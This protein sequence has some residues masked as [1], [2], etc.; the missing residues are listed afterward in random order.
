MCHVT[1]GT[2]TKRRP[3]ASNPQPRPIRLWHAHAAFKRNPGTGSGSR[4]RPAD[5]PWKQG[6][7]E[8]VGSV[9]RRFF[10]PVT[11][12]LAQHVLTRHGRREERVRQVTSIGVQT[13]SPSV[14]RKRFLTLIRCADE[15]AAG[16]RLGGAGASPQA[17]NP[18]PVQLRGEAT[19]ACCITQRHKHAPKHICRSLTEPSS[20][21]QSIFIWLISFEAQA[22]SKLL[23]AVCKG[24]LFGFK[25]GAWCRWGWRRAPEH[26]DVTD[27]VVLK[28]LRT[29]LWPAVGTDDESTATFGTLAAQFKRVPAGVD[30]AMKQTTSFHESVFWVCS[31]WWRRLLNFSPKVLK[32][33]F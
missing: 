6:D 20:P 22:G 11:G 23:L 31:V 33:H 15:N 3:L 29:Y 25:R 19:G 17:A 18:P 28:M 26:K 14:I 9:P 2:V 16:T 32:N 5:A 30:G 10:V 8:R 1:P 7:E 21:Q 4:N 12:S 13:W 24:P 27:I